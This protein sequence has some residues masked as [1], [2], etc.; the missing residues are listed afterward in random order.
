MS[1]TGS[2]PSVSTPNDLSSLQELADRNGFHQLARM[3]AVLSDWSRTGNA[4]GEIPDQ[5]ALEAALDL[6]EFLPMLPKLDG[7][8]SELDFVLGYKPLYLGLLPETDAAEIRVWQSFQGRA[9]RSAE[10]SGSD[11]HEP[12]RD[13]WTPLIHGLATFVATRRRIASAQKYRQQQQVKR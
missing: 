8:D 11:K 3:I 2:S 6:M 12:L 1:I 5:Y 13:Q 10:A 7:Y 9:F 4:D